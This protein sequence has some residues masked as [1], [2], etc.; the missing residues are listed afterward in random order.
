MVVERSNGWRNRRRVVHPHSGVFLSSAASHDSHHTLPFNLR[1]PEVLWGSGS[2][3]Q[4]R[5]DLYT[6]CKLCIRWGCVRRCVCALRSGSCC[7][8]ARKYL[9]QYAYMR[10]GPP[11]NIW[12]LLYATPTKQVKTRSPTCQT[13]PGK[14]EKLVTSYH[15]S[16]FLR[17]STKYMGGR[18]FAGIL[19]SL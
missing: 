3:S 19:L 8:N 14:G 11:G 13:S 12:D 18:S 7:F 9:C 4:V 15:R 10:K 1:Y 2:L 16:F 5:L 6:Q 17:H